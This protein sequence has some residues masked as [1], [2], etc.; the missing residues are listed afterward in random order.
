MYLFGLVADDLCGRGRELGTASSV[1]RIS[2]LGSALW[3]GLAPRAAGL[4][5]SSRQAGIVV[6][7]RGAGLVILDA[8]VSGRRRVLQG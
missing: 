7:T 3:P 5:G 6:R 4:T 8:I 2:R 1:G